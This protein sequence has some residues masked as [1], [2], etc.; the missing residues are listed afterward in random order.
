MH[1]ELVQLQVQIQQQSTVID[2]LGED[3]SNTR[4][5]VERSRPSTQRSH[6][7]VDRLEQEVHRVT[8]RWAG[9]C[10]Q[11]A[12]RYVLHPTESFS[13]SDQLN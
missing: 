5:L 12:E 1:E 4:R 6:P 3:V 11:V 13:N 9:I 7:D 2:Q 8:S 10:S